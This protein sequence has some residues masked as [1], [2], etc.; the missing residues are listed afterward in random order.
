METHFEIF[1]KLKHYIGNCVSINDELTSVLFE[2]SKLVQFKKNELIIRT[3]DISKK[4]YF[5]SEGIVR[6][7]HYHENDSEITSDFLFPPS[8][9]TSYTS[10]IDSKPSFVNVQ[11]LSNVY[12]LEL[13]KD[14]IY[15]LYKHHIE[16]EKFGRLMAEQVA[17]NS[18][19]HMFMLLNQSAEQR[20]RNLI[21]TYP[22]YIQ[23]IPLQYI[24]SYLGISKQ[25]FRS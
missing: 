15:S 3:G 10:F 25:G 24:A 13:S 1:E 12:A 16:F 5:F 19:K 8:F 17:I 6:F 4:I 9:V 20:Y 2:K 18:E 11:S 7:F 22:Q 21:D 23:F 14:T